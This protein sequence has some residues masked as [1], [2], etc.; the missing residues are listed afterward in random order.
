MT[1]ILRDCVLFSS[2]AVVIFEALIQTHGPHKGEVAPFDISAIADL[3]FSFS[4]S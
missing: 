4:D 1:C 3:S 2:V